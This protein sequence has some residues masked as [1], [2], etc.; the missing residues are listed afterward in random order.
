[1]LA[2][3]IIMAMLIER[4]WEHLQLIS[5]DNFSPR[6]KVL[7]SAVVSVAAALALRLDLLKAFEV[8]PAESYPGY[9]LTGLVLG[10]GSNVVHDI[11][12]LLGGRPGPQ[13][14]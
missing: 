1:M 10:L 8:M 14:S 2:K 13:G 3:I 7:G 4:L 6:V 9:I 12:G 5:G 11:A